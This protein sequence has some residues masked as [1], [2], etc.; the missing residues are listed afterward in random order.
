[1]TLAAL[2]AFYTYRRTAEPAI[3]FVGTGAACVAANFIMFDLIW[4]KGSGY[5]VI[6]RLDM[7]KGA[8]LMSASLV[9]WLLFALCLLATVPWRRGRAGTP[10]G[11]GTVVGVAIGVFVVLGLLDLAI[12]F[13]GSLPGLAET[14][15]AWVTLAASV[16]AAWR[17][18]L[19]RG[20]PAGWFA[21]AAAVAAGIPAA[22]LL[23]SSPWIEDAQ[24]AL[25]WYLTVPFVVG[26]TIVFGSLASMRAEA[27]DDGVRSPR[28][29]SSGGRT[30]RR[31]HR[32]DGDLSGAGRS[33]RDGLRGDVVRMDRSDDPRRSERPAEQ[34]MSARPASVA[35]PCRWNSA[36]TV[37]A[38]AERASSTV[39]WTRPIARASSRRRRT[40]FSQSSV[41]SGE[42]RPS[43]RANP[44]CTA[45][46]SA[47]GVSPV[48]RPSDGSFRTGRRSSASSA[49]RGTRSSREVDIRI[50]SSA[51]RSGSTARMLRR[52]WCRS[53]CACVR[54][55]GTASGRRRRPPCHARPP[56]STRPRGACRSLRTACPPNRTRPSS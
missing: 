5:L 42:R 10:I 34:A 22:W 25:A 16:A 40:Q 11:I 38:T 4:R 55:R 36:P 45:A 7:T 20:E 32:R 18:T 53:R 26:V 8:D 21:M 29:A 28:V 13:G 1:M 56:R 39:A 6:T 24:V 15:L 43:Q 17:L 9:S 30:P 33:V 27:S 44:A 3:A 37:Q 54:G 48:K 52:R 41:S 14:I 19:A 51:G 50:A 12:F 49:V 23:A 46:T 47:G 2:A 35:N 31:P